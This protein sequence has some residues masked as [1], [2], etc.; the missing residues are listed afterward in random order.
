MGF[1]I[2]PLLRTIAERTLR[3]NEIIER[4]EARSSD[5]LN[6]DGFADTQ[7]LISLLGVLV[8]PQEKAE[9]FLGTLT[10]SYPAV[11]DIITVQ[12]F[13]KGTRRYFRTDPG[14]DEAYVREFPMDKLPRYLRNS[15]SHFN[16]LPLAK[17]GPSGQKLFGG[18]RI[19]NRND[20]GRIT[21]VGDMT[22]ERFRPFAK[23]ILRELSQEYAGH[24]LND[25]DDP[26]D[27]LARE[28]ASTTA[29]GPPRLNHDIW[30]KWLEAHGNDFDAAKIALDRHLVAEARRRL[31]P[32]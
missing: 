11:E 20:E 12:F 30:A 5:P 32:S 28:E 18:I 27:E 1:P 23:Y 9:R 24:E 26:L 15:I 6:P 13:R 8:F 16:V 14:W 10:R 22:F 19:W 31:P 21:F 4:I 2:G 25:P 3:N 29:K 17:D 7:L